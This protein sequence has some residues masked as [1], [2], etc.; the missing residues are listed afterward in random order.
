M[1]N[2]YTIVLVTDVD[3]MEMSKGD[4][5]KEESIDILITGNIILIYFQMKLK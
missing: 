3:K 5:T 2:I 1:R 4:I